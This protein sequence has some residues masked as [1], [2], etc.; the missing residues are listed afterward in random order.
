M[1][2]KIKYGDRASDVVTITVQSLINAVI[3][4]DEVMHQTDS[5]MIAALCVEAVDN[6][7]YEVVT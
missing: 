3:I 5:N 1:T 7:N 6:G 2:I 4:Y